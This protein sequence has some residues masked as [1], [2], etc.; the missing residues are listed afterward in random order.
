MDSP[1]VVPANRRIS[2]LLLSEVEVILLVA[3]ML[4]PLL[5]E[6]FVLL[7]TDGQAFGRAFV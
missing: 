2:P 3:V 6:S 5:L 1:V 7:Q 4:V